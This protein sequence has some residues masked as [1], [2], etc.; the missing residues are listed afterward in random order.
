MA[1]L[2][3]TYRPRLWRIAFIKKRDEIIERLIPRRCMVVSIGL[4]LAGMGI[5]ALMLLGFLPVNLLLGFIGFA[6]VATG[7]VLTLTLC[8]EL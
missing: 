6:L 5:P 1:T 3:Q 4:F 8:G 2:T 7:A